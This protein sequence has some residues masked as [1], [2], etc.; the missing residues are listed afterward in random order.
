MLT[1]ILSF[2][3]SSLFRS[4]WGEV[5]SYL[6]KRREAKQELDMLEAQMR[7]E[8]QRHAQ[9]QESLRLQNDLGIKEIR[10]RSEADMSLAETEGWAKAVETA[11]KPTGYAWVDIWNGSVRPAWAT[12]SL[13]LWCLMLYRRDWV[14]T[15][16]D[17]G[18]I[19]AVI[20]FYIADR[21]LGKRGK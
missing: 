15:D 13:G 10:V 14:P 9:N 12:V 18:I 21:S 1:A 19:G 4:I 6:T 2:F 11:T 20:G 3:G 17:L 8:A 7:L 16:W 5:S